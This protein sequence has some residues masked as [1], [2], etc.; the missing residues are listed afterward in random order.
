[1]AAPTPAPYISDEELLA[2]YDPYIRKVAASLEK[3]TRGVTRSD[4]DDIAQVC[5]LDLIAITQDCR[6]H[7]E[8]CRTV[9]RRAARRQ[10]QRCIAYSDK[11]CQLFSGG[12]EYTAVTEK[13]QDDPTESYEDALTAE[14]LWARLS[15][16]QQQILSLNLGLTE[17]AMGYRQIAKALNTPERQIRHEIEVAMQLLRSAAGA[18][19]PSQ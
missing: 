15:E 19:N 8:Y 9:I 14:T 17:P 10:R 1:M 4:R 12:G 6:P 5:R 11:H 16:R 2:Q 7:P 13:L 18:N 3:S